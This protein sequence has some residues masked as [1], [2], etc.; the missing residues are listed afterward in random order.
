MITLYEYKNKNYKNNFVYKIIM[1]SYMFILII[2]LSYIYKLKSK[3]LYIFDKEK[4]NLNYCK[5][6]K[7]D[8]Y[9]NFF[10]IITNSNMSNCGLFC[11]YNIYLGC[12]ESFINQGYIP[13]VDLYSFPNVFNGFKA[14]STKNNPWE[15]YFHQPLCYT[16]KDV[17]KK[18]KNYKYSK[19]RVLGPKFTDFYN[20][21]I[22]ISYWHDFAKKYI[23]IKNEI[24]KE[25]KK[26]MKRLFHNSNNILGVLIRGTDYLSLKPIGHPITPN[27]SIVIKDIKEMDKKNNYDFFFLTTEDNFIRKKFI[28]LLGN[29]VK[30]FQNTEIKY[31]YKQKIYLSFN[32]K[33][34]GNLDNMKNYLI[35][36]II[37]SKCI[38]I[39]TSRTNGSVAAFLFNNGLYRNNKVYFLGLYE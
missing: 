33:V 26:I 27:Y 22:S 13:I 7:K 15:Y 34:A 28:L 14:N 25:S 1:I 4:E 20:K 11:Y 6:K 29:K 36:I 10:V 8:Y 9:N 23:P 39:I 3:L 24:I 12:L 37:L 35:N 17:I 32:N 31:N 18:A 38:D 19:C 5:I 30:Y 21:T 16:L 2:I